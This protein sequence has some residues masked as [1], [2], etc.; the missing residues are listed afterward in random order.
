M[1]ASLY[2]KQ[3]RQAIM[4]LGV[5]PLRALRL[6]S[7]SNPAR[8]LSVRK[9]VLGA[10]ICFISLC[11][12]VE[13]PHAIIPLCSRRDASRAPHA[14]VSVFPSLCV[15]IETPHAITPSWCY[16]V[17][18]YG[19][20]WSAVKGQNR[21]KYVG[22]NQRTLKLEISDVNWYL[23]KE[24]T[25]ALCPWLRGHAY[26]LHYHI[27]GTSPKNYMP[28]ISDI[29]VID[30]LTY[31]S[32]SHRMEVV[33]VVKELEENMGMTC[34]S[35]LIEMRD[36]S[37]NITTTNDDLVG[38]ISDGVIRSPDLEDNSLVVGLRFEDSCS[39]KQ[40]I[41]SNAIIHNFDIKIKASDKTRVIATCSYRVKKLH[42]THLC[43]GVNRAGNKQATTSWVAQ[44]IQ[45]IVKRNSDITPKDISNTLETTY[46]LTRDQMF[47]SIDDNYKWVPTL[48]SELL[49][50]NP[51]SHIT[52]QC[53]NNNKS[54]KRFFVSFKV[55]IDGFLSGCRHLIG[56]DACHLKSKYLG[57]LLSA[58]CLDGNNGLFTIAVAVAESKSKKSWEWFLKNLSKAFSCEIEQLAFISDMEK[59]LGEAI[60]VIFPNAEH[61][62]CM[63]H[64]W[65]NNKK[66]F[67]CED[68]KK[69]QK[70]VL[71]AV[72]SFS[73]HIFNATFEEIRNLS[74]GVYSYMSALTCKWSKSTF[75]HHIK[76]HYNTNNMSESFNSWVEEARSKPVVDLIDMVRGM[77][78]EQRSQRKLNCNVTTTKDHFI[79]RQSTS[80][81]GEVE[82]RYERHEVDI[83]N[84]I[85]SCGFWQVSGL[86]C[87]HGA[88]FIGSKQYNLWHSYVDDHYY[89]S[90]HRIAYEGA[91]GTLPGKDQWSILSDGEEVGSPISSRPR[92][93]PK[94]RRM[95]NFLETTKRT[96]MSHKCG[97]CNSWGHH[98]STCKNPLNGDGHRNDDGFEMPTISAP[99]EK[100]PI[101]RDVR[102]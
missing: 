64:L 60:R 65:K 40:S 2:D 29:N 66:F 10:K 86:L 6:C 19:G 97:R 81:K 75:S 17:F 35:D 102:R 1:E 25:E 58:N 30:M 51:T 14:I 83:E 7:P 15:P 36:L 96:K 78:M 12:P 73:E 79:I 39:F 91:I 3:E 59:W 90:R 13:T 4:F 37:G 53:D 89:T 16:I 18:K 55:C 47:G 67:R 100:M 61:R 45:D 57:V 54:F 44:E 42:P 85:C 92:G 76:N 95:K 31:S 82:G 93:R 28:I 98:R 11:V 70:L 69:L 41:R 5:M 8:L 99:R 63:R 21:L 101:R 43:P 34:D 68:G 71:T 46:G 32:G 33:V 94:K 87:V 38:G 80:T 20:Y 88:S 74:P 77:M 24:R 27:N 22:G 23:L 48:R 56:V 84:H 52:Y 72:N 9:V 49:K 50:R 62:V 26:D